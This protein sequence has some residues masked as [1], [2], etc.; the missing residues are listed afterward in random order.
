MTTYETEED[1]IPTGDERTIVLSDTL[2]D[3]LIVS[4]I[5]IPLQLIATDLN[6]GQVLAGMAALYV[7][8]VIGLLLTKFLPF[9]L[10]SVAWIS[11][12]G[13]AL[14]IPYLP[15]AEWFTGLVSGIDFLAL[16]VPCL[17]YAGLAISKL[18]IDVMKRSGWKILIIA[19]LVF[20]G[21]YVGSALI[22]EIT[23][24]VTS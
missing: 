4:L 7:I 9:Y 3:L 20:I 14:T 19:I 2:R 17:A 15:W 1:F 8:C 5:S 10:P 11:L 6:L 18:E 22:A 24:R 12:V 21:T 13:I 23:L 16:A